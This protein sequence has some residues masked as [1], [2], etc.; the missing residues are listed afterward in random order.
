ML[1]A[2]ALNSQIIEALIAAG[3]DPDIKDKEGKTAHQLYDEQ[4]ENYA[5]RPREIIPATTPQNRLKL[6][7]KHGLFYVVK[8]L[9]RDDP[10]LINDKNELLK[11]LPAQ[12]NYFKDYAQIKALLNP[13]RP[14]ALASPTRSESQ[15]SFS[16]N[17][18]IGPSTPSST[19]SKNAENNDTLQTDLESPAGAASPPG[20]QASFSNTSSIIP[21]SPSSSVSTN[22][23]SKKERKSWNIFKQYHQ[24]Y[25][26]DKL[27]H[28]IR[29]YEEHT[30][31]LP[32]NME[33]AKAVLDNYANDKF[34]MKHHQ[35]DVKEILQ[36]ISSGKIVDIHGLLQQLRNIK[37]E[38]QNGT[39][40]RRIAFIEKKL[41]GP[42]P[43]QTN[44]PKP[45]E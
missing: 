9:L 43:Q 29:R 21:S 10:K 31:H 18:S 6:A 23:I 4:Q 14:S 28:K 20:R 1:A 13:P 11:L 30:K 26:A 15:V 7:V 41:V 44:T 38:N 5:W 17:S 39:L 19:V 2:A 12:D 35:K 3:A 24:Q 16:N 42:E 37:L 33:K 36:G 45:G 25:H 32:T 22:T 34:G 27:A 40:S 8:T